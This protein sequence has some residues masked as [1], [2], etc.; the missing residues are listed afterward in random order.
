[1]DDG[2]A[3]MECSTTFRFEGFDDYCIC[4]KDLI[5]E[6]IIINTKN[7]EGILE[8]A[9]TFD[10]FVYNAGAIQKAK[11]KIEVQDAK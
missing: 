2:S 3:K 9:E 10:V 4:E 6:K 8:K 1:M 11:L 7:W 5:D